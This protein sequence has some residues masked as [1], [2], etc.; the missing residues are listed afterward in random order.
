M[1]GGKVGANHFLSTFYGREYLGPALEQPVV[2]PDLYEKAPEVDDGTLRRRLMLLIT[3]ESLGE[4][5]LIVLGAALLYL[6]AS[7][8][9]QRDSFE[10]APLVVMVLY[11]L[12]IG[13]ATLR[14]HNQILDIMITNL[15]LG[16]T[17]IGWMFAL[18][19]ACDWNTESGPE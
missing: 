11:P 8:L 4:A 1:F 5:L 2:S 9:I 6:T 19:W 13:I 16:W 15:W 7:Y 3:I 10:I 12:P 18:L 17:I 14:K